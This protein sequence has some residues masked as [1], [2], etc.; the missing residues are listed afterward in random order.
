MIKQISIDEF[1][2]IRTLLD[3]YVETHESGIFQLQM[4][5]QDRL[6]KALET[7][8]IGIFAEFY[9]SKPI[10]FVV[11]G[12]GFSNINVLYVDPAIED[13]KT[14]E[15]G[16][17]DYGFDYL[18]KKSDTVK[19]G[20]RKLG[21]TLEG[22]F[23]IKGF[24]KFNRKHMTLSREAIES[25]EHQKLPIEF[26]F[27]DYSSDM[28]E[29]VAEIVYKA[30]IENI[31]MQVFPEFFGTLENAIRL[32]NDTEQNRYGE[33]KEPYSKVLTCNGDMI[34]ACFLTKTSD[35]TGYIPDIC[36]L[37]EYRGRGLGKVLLVHCLKEMVRLDEGITKINLDVTLDN[38]ARYLYES[39]GYKDVRSY[40]MYSWTRNEK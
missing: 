33:Y 9:G 8:R 23:E 32:L 2:E 38:P 16:L 10:G 12:L 30:N 15:H 20:G 7:E 36:L 35:D 5:F 37:Q 26:R 27:I 4:P 17:F 25:L 13:I 22:Y 21:T 39:L 18:S 6:K 28:R 14:I 31:D 19:I 34:G 1:E 11:L 3:D 40:S 24:Q 29:E